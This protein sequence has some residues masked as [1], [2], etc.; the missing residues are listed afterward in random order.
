[1]EI[2]TISEINKI[3]NQYKDIKQFSLKY[4][5]NRREVN[6]DDL[7]NGLY[8]QAFA[9]GLGQVI[10]CYQDTVIDLEKKFLQKDTF[11]LMF[12]FKRLEKYKR[13][14]DFLQGLINGVKTQKL[15]GCS[16]LQYLQQNVLHGNY[17]IVE[18]V[19]V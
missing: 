11:T 3:S 12:L 8:L 18:A 15:H 9:D 16:I 19:L 13:I 7:Q 17:E 2:N 14:F 6:E 10:Q 4:G 5:I 1:M